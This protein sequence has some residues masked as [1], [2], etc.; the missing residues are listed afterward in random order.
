[1]TAPTW[2][3][4]PRLVATDLDGTLVRSDGSV[5]ARARAA[6][7]S[8]RGRGIPVV[9]VTGRGPR[10]IDLVRRDVGPI[11]PAVLAQGGYVVDLAT[12]EELSVDV[13]PVARSTT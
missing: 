11:G 5:S 2:D 9:G 4:V 12:G 6:I 7:A 10:L 13:L 3:R 1:M 8:L